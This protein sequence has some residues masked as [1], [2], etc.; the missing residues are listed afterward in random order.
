MSDDSSEI[1]DISDVGNLSDDQDEA[2][3]TTRSPPSKSNLEREANKLRSK[4]KILRE[5]LAEEKMADINQ[6]IEE[7]KKGSHPALGKELQELERRRAERTTV[8]HERKRVK[9]E[10]IVNDYKSKVQA[11]DDEKRVHKSVPL[12]L[13]YNDNIEADLAIIKNGKR[14]QPANTLE[15]GKLASGKL[16][17]E[18]P[19]MDELIVDTAVSSRELLHSE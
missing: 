8:S 12:H 18:E 2:M 5:A 7:V 11:L 3:E 17:A 1:G 13:F 14:K 9:V 6:E 15:A 19:V 16:E 4:F 10:N